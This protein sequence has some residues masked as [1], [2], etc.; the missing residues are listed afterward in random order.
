MGYYVNP[1]EMSK[2]DFLMKYGILITESE[3]RK[4]KAMESEAMVVVLVDNGLFMAAGVAFSDQERDAFLSPDGRKKA[5][6]LVGVK[7]LGE[8]AGLK[9]FPAK[10]GVEED[11]S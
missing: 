11:N 4:H 7:H 3:A 9:N 5:I 8:K 6:F 10:F 2:P 1:K